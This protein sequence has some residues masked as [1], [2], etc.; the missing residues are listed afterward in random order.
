MKLDNQKLPNMEMINENI[1]IFK[2]YQKNVTPYDV[3]EGESKAT[4]NFTLKRCNSLTEI[5][6]NK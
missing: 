1:N 6:K 5:E 2:N 4:N 3:L